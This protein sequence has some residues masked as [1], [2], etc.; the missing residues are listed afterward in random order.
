MSDY[1]AFSEDAIAEA[2]KL[3]AEN[4]QIVAASFNGGD[5]DIFALTEA[6]Y[7]A[8]CIS[9]TV[10]NSQICLTLPKPIS[11]QFCATVPSW[12]PN[13]T[14]AE[15]CISICTKFGIPSGAK[16][17]VTALGKVVFQKTFGLC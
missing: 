9:V 11:K 7:T 17:T 15:A 8:E 2:I 16:L 1:A 12:I 10:T 5:I 14:A 6:S 4:H 13:G 3:G